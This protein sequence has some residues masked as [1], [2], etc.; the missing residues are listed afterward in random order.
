VLPT[1]SPDA[2][3]DVVPQERDVSDAQLPENNCNLDVPER[4]EPRLLNEIVGAALV[5]TNLNQIS[6]SGVPV[7]TP[8][9]MPLLVVAPITVPSLV[10]VLVEVGT[11]YAFKQ[12]SLPGLTL[13]VIVNPEPDGSVPIEPAPAEYTLIK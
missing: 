11:R 9:G 1:V 13:A 8:I 5:A 2:L 10:N 4:F 3:I 7:Q 12:S 6:S